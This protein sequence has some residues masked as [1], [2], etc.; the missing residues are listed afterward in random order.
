MM[1]IKLFREISVMEFVWSD[2][3]YCLIVIIFAALSI[4]PLLDDLRSI[5]VDRQRQS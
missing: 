3:I 5:C 2:F 4:T 1:A